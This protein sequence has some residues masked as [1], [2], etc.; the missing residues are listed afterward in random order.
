VPQWSR[1][2]CQH[3]EQVE[4]LAF[5]CPV[6]AL[7]EQHDL[8]KV[9]T[10]TH[11]QPRMAERVTMTN[12]PMHEPKRYSVVIV[13]QGKHVAKLCYCCIGSLATQS[14]KNISQTER[15]ASKHTC[16]CIFRR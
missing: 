2:G 4:L 3:F 6:I 10:K 8:G 12:K 5:P 11:C 13:Q 1:I 14:D 16:T 7:F 9:G 15:Q